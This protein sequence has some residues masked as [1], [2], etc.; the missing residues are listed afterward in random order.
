MGVIRARRVSTRESILCERECA[1]EV[2]GIFQQVISI[3]KQSSH[4]AEQMDPVRA[5]HRCESESFPSEG[6]VA[7]EVCRG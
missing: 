7:F 6:E 5:I 3:C 1:S 2:C 4:Y